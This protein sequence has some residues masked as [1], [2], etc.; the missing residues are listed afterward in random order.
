MMAYLYTLG[1]PFTLA[2]DDF[3]NLFE[4]VFPQDP[5]F[6]AGRRP[7]R[8]PSTTT[9]ITASTTLCWPGR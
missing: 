1:V 4:T 5:D 2:F 3:S 6:A 9:R 8:S 7:S